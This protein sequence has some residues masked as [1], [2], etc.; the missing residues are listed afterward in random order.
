MKL[1]NVKK[2]VASVFCMVALLT[3]SV[4]AAAQAEVYGALPTIS[5]AAISPD[6]ET[7]AMLQYTGGRSVLVF[8][9]HAADGAKPE[10]MPIGKFK[11]R[12]I[13]WV[14]DDYLLLLMSITD[15]VKVVSG[16]EDFEF[17]RWI[18][19]NRR[20]KSANMLFQRGAGYVIES[21]GSFISSLPAK[22]DEALLARWTGYASTGSG[23]AVA[24][25]FGARK[26]TSGYSLIRVNLKNGRDKVVEAGEPDNL[27]LGRKRQWRSHHARRLGQ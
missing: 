16:V 7:I 23:T 26:D 14:N 2:T 1:Q 9:D 10:G 12:S 21:S 17:F 3:S 25:R 18:A 6:G 20:D 11:P 22:P 8:F 19:V 27:G 4:A 24:S 5:N 15:K 13:E